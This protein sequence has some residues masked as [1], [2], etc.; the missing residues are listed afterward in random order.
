MPSGVFKPYAGV[1]TAILLFVKG[2]QTE[3]VWFYDMQ[4]DGFTLDDKRSRIN[5]GGD[6][7]DIVEKWNNRKSQTE[8]KINSKFFC[9]EKK[10]I[11]E[12]DFDLSINRYKQSD[13]KEVQ[14]ESPDEIIM[15]IEK[16]EQNILDS[17]QHLKKL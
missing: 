4:S 2:G 13:Y 16:L 9:I 7:P 12:S 6:L 5:G 15:K 3:R 1:S 8:N 11:E 10:E 17:L 14:Y